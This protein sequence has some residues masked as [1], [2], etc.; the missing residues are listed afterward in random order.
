MTTCT[1]V[2]KIY[3]VVKRPGFELTSKKE[4]MCPQKSIWSATYTTA[5]ISSVESHVLPSHGH[6]LQKMS[7]L[8]ERV[9][10]IPGIM[11]PVIQSTVD[12]VCQRQSEFC[13]LSLILKMENGSH[14]TLPGAFL[15]DSEQLPGN[16]HNPWRKPWGASHEPK[17]IPHQYLGRIGIEVCLPPDS[18]VSPA[19]GHVDFCICRF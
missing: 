18:H 15:V 19:K 9:K 13:V 6:I 4:P 12:E 16:G 8:S 10:V 2:C 11:N 7:L 17:P 1:T 14:T 3:F 5:M